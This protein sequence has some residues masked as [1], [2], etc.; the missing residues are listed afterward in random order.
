MNTVFCL[1]RYNVE[2]TRNFGGLGP[3]NV[4]NP[5]FAPFGG[6]F[7]AFFELLI[8]LDGTCTCGHIVYRFSVSDT[9]ASRDNRRSPEDS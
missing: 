4:L 5:V 1:S 2:K 9:G 8:F 7:G 6:V 3:T